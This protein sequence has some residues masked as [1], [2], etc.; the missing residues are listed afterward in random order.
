MEIKK[1]ASKEK[2]VYVSN[3]VSNEEISTLLN[4]NKELQDVNQILIEKLKK[5]EYNLKVKNLFDEKFLLN[6]NTYSKEIQITM[7]E[8]RKSN[9]SKI[10]Q[11]K[12]MIVNNNKLSNDLDILQKKILTLPQSKLTTF[13]NN[14]KSILDKKFMD[15]R[16][17]SGSKAKNNQDI[18]IISEFFNSTVVYSINQKEN[19][20]YKNK[21]LLEKSMILSKFLNINQ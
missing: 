9:N 19:E 16:R 5:V 10:T 7:D 12:S 21:V 20:L 6:D 4:D 18:K 1:S 15:Q 3:N 11:L 13:S 17:K 8:L 2:S 14:E